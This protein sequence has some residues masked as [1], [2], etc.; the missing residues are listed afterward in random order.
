MRAAAAAMSRTHPR[1]HIGMEDIAT[2]YGDI[3]GQRFVI[4]TFMVKRS[5][6]LAVRSAPAA[7]WTPLAPLCQER[8]FRCPALVLRVRLGERARSPCPPTR[9]LAPHARPGPAPGR[10]AFPPAR[11]QR[12]GWRHTRAAARGRRHSGRQ[13]LVDNEPHADSRNGSSRS[14]TA[15]AANRSPASTSSR[16]RVGYSA[17]TCSTS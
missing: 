7:V 5:R 8:R 14:S 6:G 12:R 9:A 13:V 15:L 16:V 3:R 1:R 2:S 10:L 17:S 11:S 4:S